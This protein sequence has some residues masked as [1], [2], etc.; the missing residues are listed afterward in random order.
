MKHR[1]LIS[2]TLMSQPAPY[3][4][5]LSTLKAFVRE[6]RALHA[7]FAHLQ[8]M[9]KK[10]FENLDTALEDLDTHFKAVNTPQKKFLGEYTGLDAQGGLT[11]E[12]TSAHGFKAQLFTSLE[13][14][15]PG[16]DYS[17]PD[18]VEIDI[19]AG[20]VH[21][22]SITIKLPGGREDMWETNFVKALLLTVVRVWGAQSAAALDMDFWNAVKAEQ[23]RTYL[24]AGWF[25]Y[26]RNPL[27]AA[28][29]P[30]VTVA[31]VSE[32]EGGTLFQLMDRAP[33][34][35]RADDVAR[36]QKLQ[37][38]FDSWHMDHEFVAFGWPTDD[39]EQAYIRQ[40]TGAPPGR[41]YTVGFASFDGYDP[42]RKVLLFARLFR[43]P[44][45]LGTDLDPAYRADPG[46]LEKIP[47][48]V[49][50]RHQIAAVRS[51]GERTPIEWHI[52][53][54][55]TAKA[56]KTLLNDWAG[57]PEQQLR[58]VYTPF[59]GELPPLN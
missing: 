48:V 20:G 28:T 9:G 11:A 13:G 33:H 21:R 10:R 47:Y 26:L 16:W 40:I 3:S 36:A 15:K 50:A 46:I 53:I 38:A 27:L 39:A 4:A 12:S 31:S 55:D 25:C 18:Y 34:L 5:V 41:V 2:A 43:L 19:R 51:V 8:V 58:V 24:R 22:G 42:V 59:E 56:L 30:Q 32:V 57:I 54:E 29:A 23:D 45:A 14:A 52:G 49:E 1:R 37:S 17:R 44:P 7:D 6:L 35:D